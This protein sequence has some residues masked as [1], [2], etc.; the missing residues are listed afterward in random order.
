MFRAERKA[1]REIKSKETARCEDP[2]GRCCETAGLLVV[3]SCSESLM[4]VIMR[5]FF[6]HAGFTVM[7]P[8]LS[9][10]TFATGKE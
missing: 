3:V 2:L 9:F 4:N 6:L 8:Q 1:A 10:Q 7:L 5:V